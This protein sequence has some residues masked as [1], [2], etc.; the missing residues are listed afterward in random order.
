MGIDPSCQVRWSVRLPAGEEVLERLS[1]NLLH[2][3]GAA[4]AQGRGIPG[5]TNR[6]NFFEGIFFVGGWGCIFF[7]GRNAVALFV[8]LCARRRQ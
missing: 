7:G 3:A 5:R 2:L 8:S 6:I 4:E 1:L